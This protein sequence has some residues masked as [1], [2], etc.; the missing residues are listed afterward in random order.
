MTDIQIEKKRLL[1][2][3]LKLYN[4]KLKKENPNLKFVSE[5]ISNYIE[6]DYVRRYFDDKIVSLQNQIINITGKGRQKIKN[7][8]EII[9]WNNWLYYDNDI[10]TTK[11]GKVSKEKNGICPCSPL[12]VFEKFGNSDMKLWQVKSK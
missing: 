3:E 9:W 2:E 11:H 8:E 1:E 4:L 7:I 5:V 10:Y 6:G 12:E